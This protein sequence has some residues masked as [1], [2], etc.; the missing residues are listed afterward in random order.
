MSAFNQCKHKT[1]IEKVIFHSGNNECYNRFS[2]PRH[3]IDAAKRGINLSLARHEPMPVT[4]QSL[5][6]LQFQ[7]H[8]VGDALKG[9]L[10]APMGP[11][12]KGRPFHGN[13][14]ATLMIFFIAFKENDTLYWNELVDCYHAI[15]HRPPDVVK[16]M[17]PWIGIIMTPFI[18]EFPEGGAP[19]SHFELSLAWAWGEKLSRSAIG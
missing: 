9:T 3:A 6:H 14:L 4:D 8:R 17:L 7:C 1:A 19:L 15:Y 10:Y 11:H 13:S 5:S 16:P 2:C 18:D 12:V